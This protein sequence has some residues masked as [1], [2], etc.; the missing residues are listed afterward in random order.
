MDGTPDRTI[1]WRGSPDLWLDAARRAL[2]AGG[3]AAVRIGALAGGIGLSRTSF[4][5]HFDGREALLDAL[6]SVWERNTGAILSRLSAF[7]DSLPEGIF[8]LFDCWLDPTLFDPALD[9]AVRAWG[10]SDPQVWA[11]VGAADDRRIAAIAA[12]FTR[13]GRGP[14]EARV[15]ACTIYYT[16]IGYFAMRVAE[17]RAT[18]IARMPAYVATFAGEAPSAAEA[19]RFRARHGSPG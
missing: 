9:M 5:Q 17:D 19:A 16:Q 8:N 4:Y 1:G 6:L 2:I 18:R 10:L 13:F 3:V 14:D 7:A 12:L 11:R 15:R